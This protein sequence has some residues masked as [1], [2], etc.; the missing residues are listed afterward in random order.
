MRAEIINKIKQQE[1]EVQPSRRAPVIFDDESSFFSPFSP[2]K[3]LLAVFLAVFFAAF[4]RRNIQNISK[5]YQ[6]Q[7]V[8]GNV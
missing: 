1:S 2:P 3:A 5:L 7:R 6:K 4:F 8:I